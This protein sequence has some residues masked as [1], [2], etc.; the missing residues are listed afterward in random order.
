MYLTQTNRIRGLTKEQRHMLRDMCQASNGLY[1][2]ALYYLRKTFFTDKRLLTYE[3][4]YHVCKETQ[5]YALLQASLAKQILKVSC[6]EFRQFFNLTKKYPAGDY[7]YQ[8]IRIPEYRSKGGYFNLIIPPYATIIRR[9]V[10]TVPAGRALRALYPGVSIQFRY[11]DRLKDKKIRE[12]RILPDKDASDFRIQYCYDYTEK[13]E[14]TNEK[15][16]GVMAIDLGV[17]VL[18]AC[19]SDNGTSFLIDGRRIKSINHYWN[20][21]RDYY[22]QIAASQGLQRTARIERMW[23]KRNRQIRDI[24]MKS[25]HYI[26]QRCLDGGIGTIVVGCPPDENDHAF[27]NGADSFVPVPFGEFR[28]ILR[29]LCERNGILCIE[30]EEAYTSKASFMDGDI[31]PD[32]LPEQPYQGSFSGERI[33]RGLYRTKEGKLIQ[34]DLNGAANILRKSKQNFREE[35]LR[36]GLLAGPQRIRVC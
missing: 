29:G 18:A 36:D 2:A 22:G 27:G 8:Y 5:D 4:L 14:K 17:D 12:I 15:K 16:Q 7:R 1:N 6:R 23:Q 30:Q 20:Q 11:P 28:Q 33:E 19:L 34:A 13:T 10:L 35:G 31:I 26:I 24:M 9:N 21:Q 32:Y 3:E 25:A